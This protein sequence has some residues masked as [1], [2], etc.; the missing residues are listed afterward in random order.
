WDSFETSWDFKTHPFIEFKGD[1]TT[2][3]QAYLNWEQEAEQRF[4]TLKS[5]EEELKRIF[6]DLY[7]LQDELTP[8]VDDKEV[9]V[10]RADQARDVKSFISYAVGLMLGRYSLDQEGL[11][12]AGGSFDS[13]KYNIFTQ[14]ENN[15]IQ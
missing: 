12:F 1:A 2:I 11:A 9:T 3:A 14:D 10:S 7:G 8:E 4:Q 5:N 13:S 15:V 6:I